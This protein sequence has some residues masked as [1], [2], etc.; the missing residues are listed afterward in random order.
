MRR[1][2][3]PAPAPA[4]LALGL[5]LALLLPAL[6]GFAALAADPAPAG[7]RHVVAYY[8]HGKLRCKTCVGMEGMATEVLKT[9][10]P[11]QLKDRRIDW[12][13]VNYDDEANEHF[14][15]DYQLVGPSLVLVELAG[16]KQ[17]RYRNLDKI[18]QLA[19]QEDEFKQYVRTQI[20]AF[21]KQ[22]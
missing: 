13:V 1:R 4:L 3:S 15:K 16:G 7:E 21:L 2:F 17:V 14:I 11:A 8:F 19:H 9:D 12:R 22:G 20:A 6:A 10:F 18:W 5:A